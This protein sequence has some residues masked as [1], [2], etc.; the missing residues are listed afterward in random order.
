[1]V[2]YEGPYVHNGELIEGKALL[3]ALNLLSPNSRTRYRRAESDGKVVRM[4]SHPNWAILFPPLEPED[5][6]YL[7]P[8]L[9]EFFSVVGYKSSDELLR[10]K[11]FRVDD[12]KKIK[13]IFEYMNSKTKI[14]L[15]PGTTYDGHLSEIVKRS[16]Y[17]RLLKQASDKQNV[18]AEGI[19]EQELRILLEAAKYGTTHPID[20]ESQNKY[21][22]LNNWRDFNVVSFGVQ[23]VPE[24]KIGVPINRDLSKGYIKIEFELYLP[25]HSDKRDAKIEIALDDFRKMTEGTK[26]NVGDNK[27]AGEQLQADFNSR[28]IN[29]DLL[30]FMNRLY[31]YGVN[32]ALSS[33]IMQPQGV[34]YAQSRL[35][36][37]RI[38]AAATPF[39]SDMG[40][41]SVAV[42]YHEH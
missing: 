33:P 32:R 17:L 36:D 40:I 11:E 4:M 29:R 8:N 28:K 12:S 42:T 37:F 7:F 39:D 21:Y 15:K 18:L 22:G 9:P 1:M 5:V 25:S 35:D 20:A 6:S 19:L 27:Y 14:P 2:D 23:I 31:V 10:P 41:K 3:I 16:K 26:Y 24:F 38:R 30:K 13:E 34:D